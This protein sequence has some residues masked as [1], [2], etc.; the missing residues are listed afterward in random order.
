MQRVIKW[1]AER[2]YECKRT[3]YESYVHNGCIFNIDIYRI[4]NGMYIRAK[5]ETSKR[6]YCL[7]ADEEAFKKDEV[8]VVRH[9]EDETYQQKR[10]HYYCG[11]CESCSTVR[12]ACNIMLERSQENFILAIDEENLFPPRSGNKLSIKIK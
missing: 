4:S 8:F 9:Q 5:E 3:G 12:G 10:I 6:L 11:V 7:Y 1:L 2:G